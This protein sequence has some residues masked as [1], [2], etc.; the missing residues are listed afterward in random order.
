MEEELR[1]E[2]AEYEEEVLLPL[3][4]SSAEVAELDMAK[5]KKLMLVFFID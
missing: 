3:T 2:V 4:E 1:E 5:I